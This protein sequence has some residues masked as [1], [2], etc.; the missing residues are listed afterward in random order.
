MAVTDKCKSFSYLIIYIAQKFIKFIY[1]YEVANNCY[2][3]NCI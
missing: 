1:V 3:P 2:F